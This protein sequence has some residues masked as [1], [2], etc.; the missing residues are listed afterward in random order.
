MPEG[1]QS[2][3]DILDLINSRAL[4]PNLKSLDM[5]MQSHLNFILISLNLP[6]QEGHINDPMEYIIESLEKKHKKEE[7]N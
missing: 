2:K 5:S 7:N 1:Y 3:Y 4:N 6:P